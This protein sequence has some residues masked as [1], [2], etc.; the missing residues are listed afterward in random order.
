VRYRKPLNTLYTVIKSAIPV[1]KNIK[2][3]DMSNEVIFTHPS[4][5]QVRMI[6]E[7]NGKKHLSYRVSESHQWSSINKY[8]AKIKLKHSVDFYEACRALDWFD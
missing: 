6:E 2:I 5:K 3:Q 8:N 7:M 4:G 1:R